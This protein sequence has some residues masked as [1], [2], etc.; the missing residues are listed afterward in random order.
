MVST[1]PYHPPCR[2]LHSEMRTALT[3]ETLKQN[4]SELEKRH[5]TAFSQDKSDY[6]VMARICITEGVSRG[7]RRKEVVTDNCHVRVEQRISSSTTADTHTLAANAAQ[8]NCHPLCGKKWTCP[9][10]RKM[11]T[12]FRSR[13]STK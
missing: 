12:D 5:F 10:H 6:Y 4:H 1:P 3:H 7:K 2:A 11:K 9:F 8:M 13:T